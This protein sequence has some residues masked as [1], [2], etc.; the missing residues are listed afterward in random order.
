MTE[1]RF[2]MAGGSGSVGAV[3]G[4][5]GSGVV[6]SFEHVGNVFWVVYLRF[7]F[8]VAGG[9]NFGGMGGGIGAEIS[10]A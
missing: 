3:V 8:V 7:G 6:R 2:G 5:G 9:R 1:K 10:L 4:G